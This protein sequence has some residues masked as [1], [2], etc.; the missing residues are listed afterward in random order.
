MFRDFVS[1]ALPLSGSV[2]QQLEAVTA[3]RDFF[4]EKYAAQMNEMN[5]LQTELK[6]SR[7]MI[8]KLRS[9]I[10]DLEVERAR[11]AGESSDCFSPVKIVSTGEKLKTPQKNEGGSANTSITS[12]ATSVDSTRSSPDGMENDVSCAGVNS[13]KIQCIADSLVSDINTSDSTEEILRCDDDDVK[14]AGMN[15]PV[16]EEDVIA[17]DDNSTDTDEAD[18]CDESADDEDGADQIRAKAER[19]LIWA[20]YQAQRRSTP[21]KDSSNG[22]DT[23][24]IDGD[25]VTHSE[26]TS[27]TSTPKCSISNIPSLKSSKSLL[28]DSSSLGSTS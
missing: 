27:P 22:Y 6:E 16:A 26:V 23:D 18:D 10:L 7:R 14:K 4:R 28:D 13:S 11:M 19:M 3:E 12:A 8:D 24:N 1:N 17:D 2:Q 15:P 9:Q 21:T 25:S 5:S 20:N